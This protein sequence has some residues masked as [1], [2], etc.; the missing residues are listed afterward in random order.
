MSDLTLLYYTASIIKGSV[1]QKIRDN[2]LTITQNQFP[3]VSVSQ[4]PIDFGQNVCVGPI[5]KSKYNLY[6]QILIGLKEVKTKYVACIEDDTLYSPT[7]FIYRPKPGIFGYER[8]YWIV[9]YGY[10]W[11]AP[12]VSKRGGM[13]GCIS[14][15][16]T[17]LSN[18][19]TRYAL[20]PV[21]PL[22]QRNK[23]LFWGEPGYHDQL[24]GMLNHQLTFFESEN[25]SVIFNHG[26]AIGYS[27]NRNYAKHFIF[28]APENIA[29]NLQGFGPA[30]KLRDYYWS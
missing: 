14:E 10:Y 2:L 22:P 26:K 8:N 3:V 24:Y 15:T 20:Y 29:Y 17:L 30:T 25:P 23:Y 13:W 28:D 1:A 12:D 21:D 16:E 5:G 27:Q 4:Q 9:D 18:L 7:H 11:R 19:S 6:K